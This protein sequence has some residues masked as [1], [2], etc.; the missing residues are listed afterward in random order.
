MNEFKKNIFK[1]RTFAPILVQSLISDSSVSSSIC[2]ITALN[3][4]Y[5]K[6]S[7]DFLNTGD[8]IYT[9]NDESTL[10]IGEAGKYYFI[11]PSD[12]V[13]TY[14]ITI[15]VLGVLTIFTICP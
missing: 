5:I 12:G 15:S 13:S 1:K 9:T 4:V 2:G 10:F 14:V 8:I 6:K 7:N 3:T 11:E